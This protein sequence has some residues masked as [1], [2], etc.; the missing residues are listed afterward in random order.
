MQWKSASSWLLFCTLFLTGCRPAAP[1]Q[2]TPA[3]PHQGV[4]LRIACP[5]EEV[6][7]RL[8]G[9]A[10]SWALRQG[11]KLRVTTYDPSAEAGPA[12]AGPADVWVLAPAELPRWAAADKLAAVPTVYTTRESSYSWT[13]L[14]PPYREQLILWGGTA[15][16][17]AVL[18]ESPLC[19]YRADW[20]ENAAFRE[21]F[22]HQFGHPFDAPATWEQFLWIAEYFRDHPVSAS[23]DKA[24]SKSTPSL[25]PLPRDDA[26]L[27][28][29]FYTVAAGFA[30][31]AVP[32]DEARR[33]DYQDD[34]FSFHYDL[35]TGRPRIAE[36]G[37]VHALE[38]LQRLQKCRP[39][40]T[41]DHPDEA[42]REGRA[43]LCLTDAPRL[44]A[45]QQAPG[46]HD[47]IGVSR[48]PGG[49][50]YFDFAKGQSQPTP[51]GNR[52]P[53]L[54]GG[55]WLAVVPRT[56]EHSDAAFDLLAD[57]SGPKTSTQIFLGE[58]DRG[59]PIRSEQLYRER[60]DSFDLNDKQTLHLRE[61]LQSTL[62]HRGLRN[63]A[64]CL[65]TPRQ[66]AHRAALVKEVRAALLGDTVAAKA[67]Q[68]VAAAWSQLDREQG[69]DAHKADYRRSLGLLAE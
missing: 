50:V 47:K 49:D 26:D 36:P 44:K 53:Y 38:L 23:A 55:S 14:L 3:A 68:K 29:L 45:F 48:I 17:L 57:L 30:R 11:A 35:K 62:L 51:N 7:Q 64:L 28:R 59:G 69:P 21:A 1:A 56:S 34:V 32:A 58:T 18:G 20:L 6:A 27:D 8:R 60:W 61:A 46:L 66:A 22:Q 41:A 15:Y 19:C 63:P 67:L 5:S 25:P 16:G 12:S 33:A 39:A 43:V 52:V 10:Q 40:G 4:E 54:G 42:F 13:D 31:R 65:R 2:D 24:G 9:P 37:F